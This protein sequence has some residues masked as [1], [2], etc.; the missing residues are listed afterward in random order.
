MIKNNKIISMSFFLQAIL[1][2]L[3]IT[4]QGI[5]KTIFFGGFWLF[6]IIALVSLLNKNKWEITEIF[7]FSSSSI[8]I[9]FAVLLATRNLYDK[10]GVGVTITGLLIITGVINA[11][12]KEKKTMRNN[13][14]IIATKEKIKQHKENKKEKKEKKQREEEKVYFTTT[15]GKTYHNKNCGLIKGRK[16]IPVTTSEVKKQ[17]LKPC[18]RCL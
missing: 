2:I 4:S 7:S 18:K 13:K 3:T 9:L 5:T 17:G 14:K 15:R 11:I 8:A 1:I 6:L 12:K 10:I 16:T